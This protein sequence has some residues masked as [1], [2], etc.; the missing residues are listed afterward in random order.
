M[1]NVSCDRYQIYNAGNLTLETLTYIKIFVEGEVDRLKAEKNLI[2]SMNKSI[3]L[4]AG[5]TKYSMSIQFERRAIH[6][7]SLLHEGNFESSCY[8]RFS[9]APNKDFI[10]IEDYRSVHVAQLLVCLHTSFSRHEFRLDWSKLTIQLVNYDIKLHFDEF[11]IMADGT[12]S[13]C[14]DRVSSFFTDV[15]KVPSH[16]STLAVLTTVCITISITCLILTLIT[17]GLFRTLRTL[18]GK[19][20]ICMIV[21]LLTAQ[22]TM[23]ILPHVQRI[24]EV[25][26]LF[27]ALS[28]FAWLSYFACLSVCSVHMF[29]VFTGRLSSHSDSNTSANKTIARYC[30]FSI[31]VPAVVVLMVVII[32]L[33]TSSG[34]ESGYSSYRCFIS[35]KNVFIA[36]LVTPLILMCVSNFFF[37]VFTAVK[38]K[39]TPKVQKNKPDN[40]QV[41]VYCKLFVLTG[42]TWIIQ[43]VDTFLLESFL[44][45]LSVIF[46]CSQGIFIFLSYTCNKRVFMLYKQLCRKRSTYANSG[47]TSGA[48]RNMTRSTEI[49]KLNSQSNSAV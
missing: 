41:I 2:A 27:G 26:I 20:N 5:Y 30:L 10:S 43:V 9:S 16:V 34:L 39:N 18:P 6:V 49:S 24:A 31:G 45:Y 29:R 7:P 28:H 25:C 44:S 33:A 14:L 37:F 47:S 22:I 42:L 21:S 32:S 36:T 40:L 23:L 48:G 8:L 4:T 46:N 1:S 19:N 13:V 11:Q 3:Q 17:Y 38:I 12:A 35:E 15:S